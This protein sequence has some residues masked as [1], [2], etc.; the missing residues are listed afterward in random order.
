KNNNLKRTSYYNQAVFYGT[1]AYELATQINSQFIINSSA[2]QLQR[3]FTKLGNKNE[4]LKYAEIVIL[5]K[6]SLFNDD[7]NRLITEMDTKYQSEKKQLE[8][9][10]LEK[11]KALDKET[12]ARK[13]AETKK[14]KLIILFV[15]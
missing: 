5:T 4:A 8:I 3:A 13:E 9:E 15:V 6:D 10:K 11:Q 7:K 14:Q 1:K 12:I 2:A